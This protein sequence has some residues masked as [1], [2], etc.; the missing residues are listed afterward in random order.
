MNT[1]LLYNKI[2]F[3]N[4]EHKVPIYQQY[5]AD[6]K[7]T[8]KKKTNKTG[9]CYKLVLIN[10]YPDDRIFKFLSFCSSIKSNWESKVLLFPTQETFSNLISLSAYAWLRDVGPIIIGMKETYVIKQKFFWVYCQAA[11]FLY[12]LSI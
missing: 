8:R 7:V 6:K 1:F 2:T 12:V 9:D 10:F 11:R 5:I 4:M 3:K